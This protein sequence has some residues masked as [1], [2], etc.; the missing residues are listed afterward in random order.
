MAGH[1]PFRQVD[2]KLQNSRLIWLSTTSDEGDSHCVPVS[3]WWQSEAKRLY[4]VSKRRAAKVR[5]LS[6]EPRVILHAG[7]GDAMVILEGMAEAVLDAQEQQQ[8]NDSWQAKYTGTTALNDRE[9]LLY[10]VQI[11]QVIVREF[12]GDQNST[13]WQ[14]EDATV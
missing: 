5:H 8:I 12:S 7:E 2:L 3:F 14:L 11:S 6:H 9:I 13:K 1:I 4:F 10:R